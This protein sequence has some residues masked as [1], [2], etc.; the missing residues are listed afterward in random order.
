VLFV[1]HGRAP[2]RTTRRKWDALSEFLQ[3]RIIVESAA[4]SMCGDNRIVP[5]KPMALESLRG[6]GFYARLPIVVRRQLRCFRPDVI[7]TQSPYDAIPALLARWSAGGKSVPLVVEVHGDWRSATRLYGSRW[8][9]LLSPL[10]DAAAVWALRRASAIRAIGP[11]MSTMAERA[12]GKAPL[13]VFP[14]FHDAETYFGTPCVPLPVTPTA[15]WVGRLER[16]K[17]PELLAAAW[18][19]VAEAV[20]NARLIVVGAGRLE[21]VMSRLKDEYPDRVRVYDRLAPVDLLVLF[22]SATTL[23][24]PS[25]SEGLGRVIIEA[26]ARG[27]PVIATRVG[28]ITDLVQHEVNGLLVPSSDTTALAEALIRLL[29]DKALAT[30]LGERARANVEAYQWTADR[31]ARAMRD[32]VH[33]TLAKSRGATANE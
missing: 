11:S 30:R 25:R 26:F 2:D 3:I 8:R 24:L 17:N 28:G 21:S 15:L 19:F 23:V 5:L 33:D 13:A 22:D 27:R 12:A 32:L 20:P 7:V 6:A 18:T 31:Y 9:R 1:G 29:K 16:A 4:L 10:G 14:T